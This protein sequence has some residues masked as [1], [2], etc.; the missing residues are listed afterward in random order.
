MRHVLR[1]LEGQVVP[2]NFP[3]IVLTGPPDTDIRQYPARTFW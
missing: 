2:K 3:A 1:L